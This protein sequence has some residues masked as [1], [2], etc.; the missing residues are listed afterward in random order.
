MYG[1]LLDRFGEFPPQVQNLIA[2]MRIKELLRQLNAIRL[3][4]SRIKG[5]DRMIL[6]FHQDG[7]PGAEQIVRNAA[8]RKKWSLLPDSRLSV[9]LK[10]RDEDIQMTE[11][12]KRGLQTVLEA[13]KN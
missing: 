6:T 10:P 1:E 11:N 4:V 7:P 8:S 5:L 12:I 13:A 3:D 9:D 2:V